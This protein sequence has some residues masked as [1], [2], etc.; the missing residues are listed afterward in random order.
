MTLIGLLSTELRA[1]LIWLIHTK[2]FKNKNKQ[3]SV[4]GRRLILM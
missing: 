1:N 4:D 3:D 2:F